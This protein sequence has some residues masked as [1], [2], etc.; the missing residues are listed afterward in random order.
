MWSPSRPTSSP[1]QPP[2]QRPGSALMHGG[3]LPMVSN[4]PYN[5]RSTYIGRSLLIK[6]EVSGS[7]PI[8]IEGRVEGAIS[9]PGSHLSI[10]RDG[11]VMSTVQ[12][13]EVIVRGTVHGKLTAS[14]R[15]EIHSGG[16]LMGDVAAGRISI[17]DGAYFQGSIDMRRPDPK[18]HLG[19][20]SDKVNAEKR[21][22]PVDEPQQLQA[23]TT[24]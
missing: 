2:G 7:E 3:A 19:I 1:P 10:G 6:G 18:A 21:L 13:G 22:S 11:M 24:R 4:P 14:D 5:E 8:H 16:S 23:L 20:N 17:E 15:V 12:A 9:L